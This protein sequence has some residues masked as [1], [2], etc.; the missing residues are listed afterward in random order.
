[1]SSETERSSRPGRLLSHNHLCY[2]GN[3]FTHDLY[4]AW[5][6]V[7]LMERLGEMSPEEA[8]RWQHGIF[9]LMERWGLE[10]DDLVPTSAS[11]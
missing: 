8:I 10:P 9:G 6:C 2:S 11:R 5:R 1:M 7:D 3:G 4:P